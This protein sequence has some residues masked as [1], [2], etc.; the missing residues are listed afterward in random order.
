MIGAVSDAVHFDDTRASQT[1]SATNQ[2]DAVVGQ[3]ALLAGVG[4]IRDHEV[5]PRE[6]SIDVDLRRCGRVVRGLRRLAG[7]QQRLRRD[8][9]PVRA[10]ATDEFALDE[11]DTQAAFGERTRAVLA[12]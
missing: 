11:R 2:V 9:G 8:A 4:I 7:A 3:P 10:L 5:A 1:A 12:G 6:R